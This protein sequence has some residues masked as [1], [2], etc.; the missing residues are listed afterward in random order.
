MQF[1]T[2]D[3]HDHVGESV[4]HRE[5]H[6]PASAI[7]ETLRCHGI[8]ASICDVKAGKTPIGEVL[9]AQATEHEAD[10]L[11]MGAYGHARLH[12]FVFGGAT[13]HVLKNMTIPVLFSH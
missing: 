10:L 3:E 9:C 4:L 12:E 6:L 8:E 13:R 1:L 2:I 11:V 7:A 5:E